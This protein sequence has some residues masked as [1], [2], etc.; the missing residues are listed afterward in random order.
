MLT[1]HLDVA[2]PSRKRSP[3][4]ISSYRSLCTHQIFPR[5]GASVPTGCA[6]RT[7]R[8]AARRCSPP[9]WPTRASGRSTPSFQAPIALQ[10]ARGNLARNPCRFVE[11]PAAPESE[12][13][14]LTVAEAASLAAVAAEDPNGRRWA[15]GLGLGLRQGEA[16]GMR[17][18]YLNL[19]TGEICGSGISFSAEPGSTAATTR[20]SARGRT[21]R[22]G[23]AR[24]S[25][26][27]TPGPARH[28]ARPAATPMR[29][30]ARSG[31]TAA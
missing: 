29:A 3:S 4:T 10:V 31:K 2:L 1:R 12:M 28:L 20:G 8:T 24:K 6:P 14:K 18:Q 9:A 17:W 27:G 11:P 19:D 26:G 25:A 15:L 23:R 22:P 16:L 30:G 13:P 7:L 21:A 5:W